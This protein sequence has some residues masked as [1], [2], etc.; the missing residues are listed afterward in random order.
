MT[1]LHLSC[2][3]LFLFITI[4]EN[5]P[6]V[7]GQTILATTKSSIAKVTEVYDESI[8]SRRLFLGLILTKRIRSHLFFLAHTPPRWSKDYSHIDSARRKGH[9]ESSGGSI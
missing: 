5:G 9:L 7:N 8:S 6:Q 1:Q 4:H 2:R 3:F